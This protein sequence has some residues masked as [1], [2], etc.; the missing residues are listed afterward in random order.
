[1]TST[2]QM[3]R[4]KITTPKIVWL[5]LLQY[6][7]VTALETLY[8]S[9]WIS[10]NFVCFFSFHVSFE[11]HI[12]CYNTDMCAVLHTHNMHV[13]GFG[14]L[15]F[16][17]VCLSCLLTL[18]NKK[19]FCYRNANSANGSANDFRNLAEIVY[20]LFKPAAHADC[21]AFGMRNKYDDDDE[22]KNFWF[23]F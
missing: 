19:N 9:K 15:L 5:Y 4:K 14:F 18:L 13:I 1:M 3:C 12:S 17:F 11:F 8:T 16:F 22:K 23:F 6:F 7:T 10:W 2:Q 21:L 20:D